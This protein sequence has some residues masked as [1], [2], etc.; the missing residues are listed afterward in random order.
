MPTLLVSVSPAAI[1]GGKALIKGRT[2]LVYFF[3]F[4]HPT[5]CNK[6]TDK[7]LD[8][9]LPEGQ[10]GKFLRWFWEVAYFPNP[11]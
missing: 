2:Q 6:E 4:W 8:Y 1:N 7:L 5:R 11:E 9:L 3:D 10:E